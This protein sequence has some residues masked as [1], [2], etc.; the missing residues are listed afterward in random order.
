M[1]M[2]FIL[3]TECHCLKYIEVKL[4][5]A[6]M[7]FVPG[8]RKEFCSFFMTFKCVRQPIEF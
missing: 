3:F 5:K 4:T 6:I 7:L 2:P 1:I 8:P